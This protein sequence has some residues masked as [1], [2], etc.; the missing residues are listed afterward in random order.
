MARRLLVVLA[1]AALADAMPAQSNEG[2]GTPLI[3]LRPA[4]AFAREGCV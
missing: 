4:N 1:T 3:P 2:I